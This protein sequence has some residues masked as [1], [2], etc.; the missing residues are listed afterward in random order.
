VKVVFALS[1]NARPLT[2]EQVGSVDA[3]LQS[4][5]QHFDNLDHGA[6]PAVFLSSTP[7]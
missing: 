7:P 2:A 3:V 5:D 6:G 4:H 1:R